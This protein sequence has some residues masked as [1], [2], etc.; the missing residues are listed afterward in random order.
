[1]FEFL[2]H[3]FERIEYAEYGDCDCRTGYSEVDEEYG[4]EG[5]A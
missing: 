1:V 4:I 2:S 5:G 3:V